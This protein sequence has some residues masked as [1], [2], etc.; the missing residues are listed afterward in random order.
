MEIGLPTRYELHEQIGKGTFSVIRKCRDTQTDG[1]CAVKIVDISRMNTTTGLTR[2][3]LVHECQICRK[4]DHPHIVKM[5]G[6][7]DVDNTVYMVF[8]YMD[9]ADL[10]FEIV[11]R[12][13]AGFVY[14]E[15][16][17]SHYLRQVL[18]ALAYIHKM[19]II[20][21]D[22]KPH[23]ILLAN[24]ENS[25]P[26]KLADFGVARILDSS[27]LI[28]SGR[29]GTPHFMSPEVVK[30]IPYGK[31]NDVWGCGVIMFILVSG[32]FPF[33]GTGEKIYDV[34]ST[35]DYTMRPKQWDL[36]SED[37]K[38]L[39]RSLLAYDQ[40]NR[41]TAEQALAHP[42]LKD[43]EIAPRNHLQE[44]VD[45]MKKFNARRKLKGAVLAAVAS[46]K[47]VDALLPNGD[48]HKNGLGPGHNVDEFHHDDSELNAAGSVA[49]LLDSLEE[50]EILSQ[51]KKSDI[52]FLH[53]FLDN[54]KFQ[55][56]LE[57]YDR[58]Q[59]WSLISERSRS[60]IQPDA[61]QTSKEAM[62][63]VEIPAEEDDD[64]FELQNIMKE[65]NMVA[66]L[67][68]HDN[69]LNVRKEEERQ[70]MSDVDDRSDT[71]PKEAVTRVRL[72]QFEKTTNEPMGITLK[73]TDNRVYV[74][75]IMHGGMIHRQGTLHPGDEIREL[76]GESVE[77]KSIESLQSI[78]KQASGTVTFKIVPSFRHENTERGSFV[79][80]LFSYDPRGDELIPCQ[81]A[82]LAFQVGDVLEIVS[83]TDFNWWQAVK[84]SDKNLAGLVPSPELQ[85]WRVGYAASEKA[86]K[87]RAS[88]LGFRKKKRYKDKYVLKY[89]AVFDQ[90]DLVTYEEVVKQDNFRRKTL[91]LLGAHGVGRR[92][93]KNTLIN[94]N[95]GKYAYPIPH[96]TRQAKPGEE[97][98]KNYFFISTD[99]MLADVEQNKYLEFGSH[100]GAMYG[101]KLDTV[102]NIISQGKM[103][104]LDVEP[105]VW[106]ITECKII[107]K[108]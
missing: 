4:L 68:A 62:D 102:R 3:D 57:I 100:E 1:L 17:A 5:L 70:S 25:A 97:D 8:E 27:E 19:N 82:G 75:R 88:C 23:N 66:L 32:A 30:R 103:P 46:R 45:E 52:D 81:Q 13:N 106:N 7:Y 71:L 42:W 26:V 2:E 90:L 11:N 44:C 31:P 104:L 77:N 92:H 29:I 65:P 58:V 49:Q 6:A 24:K 87:N 38:D 21:R 39:V 20:H 107:Y 108:F 33:N 54:N 15:A 84:V 79:K 9:G 63:T 98:G 50:V 105:Q 99:T 53:R 60:H 96:T 83:K 36:I 28:T 34:I 69:I 16:V 64:C 95:P 101:T 76:D 61:T 94:R 56:L 18:D 51:A 74:A 55:S 37:A 78:L 91:V 22:I 85:E 14:S 47:F 59:D 89:N 73:R 43:R 40:T 67:E 41:I 93:I 80:A 12:V 48:L 10:C 72:V 86:R 35:G